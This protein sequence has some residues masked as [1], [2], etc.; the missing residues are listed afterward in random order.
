MALVLKALAVA[1][2][3][4][5]L[6]APGAAAATGA[7]F[8]FGVDTQARGDA[9]I[10][11][12]AGA[13]GDRMIVTYAESAPALVARRIP[14]GAE[15]TDAEHVVAARE[16]ARPVD[17][18]ALTY[19]PRAREY[20]LAFYWWTPEKDSFTE[21]LV[22]RIAPDGRPLGEPVPVSHGRARGLQPADPEILYEPR[23][24]GYLAVWGGADE[25]GH[26][27][28]FIYSQRL[29]SRGRPTSTDDTRLGTQ[30]TFERHVARDATS[31][32]FLLA[33]AAVRNDRSLLV[34][35][36]LDS[37][38]RPVAPQRPVALPRHV[39]EFRIAY[40]ARSRRYAVALGIWRAPQ[41]IELRTLDRSGRRLSGRVAGMPAP[42]WAGGVDLKDIVYAS[43][44][45]RFLVT[46]SF[47]DD[48]MNA[49]TFYYPRG[50]RIGGDGRRLAGG[51]LSFGERGKRQP[52]TGLGPLPI[53]DPR[54][55]EHLVIWNESRPAFT[56]ELW[57][58]RVGAR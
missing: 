32:G 58:R 23:S 6:L 39:G 37:S 2:L 20:L 50:Q 56:S 55:D 26:L 19:N 45:D 4:A 16:G 3:G 29:D 40:G 5:C 36:R 18:I 24:G 57:G 11:H 42:S 53:Y 17:N 54:E 25:R 21:L 33:H 52:T 49:G 27:R 31:G 43:R 30:T 7:P 47:V 14:R 13:G 35:R 44:A 34:T 46:W 28:K 48:Q 8:S 12:A 9:N 41:R 38:G 15:R 1:A 10:A 51:R 22:Q